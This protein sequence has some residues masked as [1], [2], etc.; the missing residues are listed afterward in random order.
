MR[1]AD[2]HGP[3]VASCVSLALWASLPADLHGQID[4][5]RLDDHQSPTSFKS[6]WN[7]Y[8]PTRFEVADGGLGKVQLRFDD[9][10]AGVTI[11]L[12]AGEAEQFVNLSERV[13]AGTADQGAEI[14]FTA[15]FK[16]GPTW[17]RTGA[18][19]GRGV[20]SHSTGPRG[21]HYQL[22]FHRLISETSNYTTYL[23]GTLHFSAG[24]LTQVTAV[25]NDG[26]G[27]DSSTA[28]RGRN[29]GYA[30]IIP[31]QTGR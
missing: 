24:L 10:Q 19:M 13:M 11:V 25:I 28:S 3:L 8:S 2:S 23:P 14:A 16:L 22:E 7:Q 29:C 5:I 4:C 18:H 20:L 21:D 30:G 26:V 6:A 15:W 1:L 27:T 12:D 17:H 9:A 31:D